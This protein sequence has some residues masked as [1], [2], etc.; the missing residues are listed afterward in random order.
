MR[1]IRRAVAVL[2][3]AGL[4]AAGTVLGIALLTAAPAAAS[5]AHAVDISS[6]AF[7]PAL[8]TVT[9][10]DTVTW[11]NADQAPHDVTTTSAPVAIHG[12]RMEKGQSWSYTF[13][14]PGR[15]AYICSIHPDMKATV[16]VQPAPTHSAA[17]HTTAAHSA[18]AKTRYTTVP[19]A[20][21]GM[22]MPATH[23]SKRGHATATSRSTPSPAA[24]TSAPAASAPAPVAAALPPAS[25]TPERP[26]RP[27]LIVAGGI[28][29]LATL[30]LLLLAA[31]AELAEP[32]PG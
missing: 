17:T 12:S 23:R 21:G 31:R 32:P 24:T 28:A 16:I 27:L 25:T 6:Y 19:A 26:L 5:T 22:A 13:T 1:V 29:G 7:H 4:A 18:P 20:G 11:T 2:L 8:L 10:G 3:A 14:T 15:Y 30:C 9:A